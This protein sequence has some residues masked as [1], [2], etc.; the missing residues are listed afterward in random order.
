LA[1]MV[2]RARWEVI[3]QKVDIAAG[4]LEILAADRHVSVP[5]REPSERVSKP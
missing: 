1:W 4:R 2:L 5:S 3:H